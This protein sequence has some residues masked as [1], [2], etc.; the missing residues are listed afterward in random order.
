MR[1][2]RSCQTPGLVLES[3]SS[4]CGG[5]GGC[6]CLACPIVSLRVAPAGSEAAVSRVRLIETQHRPTH[7]HGTLREESRNRHLAPTRDPAMAVNLTKNKSSLLAAYQ[8]VVNEKADTDW[9]L[10]TY[11][12][13]SNDVKTAG[14]GSGG[15]EELVEE[16]SSGKVMYAFA[17]VKDPNTGLAKYVLINWTG[18]GVKDSQKGICANHVSAIAAFFKGAHVTVNA[19][20]EEDVEPDQIREK[21]A[22]ASGSNYSIHK[23]KPRVADNKPQGPVASVYKKT[24]AASEIRRVKD[25]SFWAKTQQEEAQRK[26]EEQKRADME[27]GRLE[28]ERKEREQAEAAER[29]RHVRDKEQ[30]ISQQRE[31]EERAEAEKQARE[32]EKWA[33]QERRSHEDRQREN[34]EG[35]GKAAEAASLVS[36][37]AADPREMF[38]QQAG[39]PSP[40]PEAPQGPLPGVRNAAPKREPENVRPPSPEQPPWEGDPEPVDEPEEEEEEVH[41]VGREEVE[42]PEERAEEPDHGGNAKSEGLGQCARALYDYQ[43]ADDTEISFDPGDLISN[44]EQIDDGWWNGSGPD[45]SRGMFPANYVELVE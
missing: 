35:G 10:F 21:V 26:A 42:E 16:L 36:Q 44:I 24:D 34:N 1:C 15:L 13:N 43:A 18:E 9:A 19:R 7:H 3:D 5:V 29:D 14:T 8:Q 37:R 17:R 2:Y 33:E 22:K 28:A 6:V 25:N 45:G 20:S 39:R 23:E 40:A 38:K 41:P 30:K 32:K 11:E 27:R 4:L 12:G 31:L